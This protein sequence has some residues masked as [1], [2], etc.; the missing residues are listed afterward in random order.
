[1]LKGCE[2]EKELTE[3]IKEFRDDELEHKDIGLAS[4]AELA[5]M[6]HLLSNVVSF[7][8]KA[9]IGISKKL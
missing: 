3:S 4:E 9:A 1:M 5:P 7:I 2:N 8:T 6:Y